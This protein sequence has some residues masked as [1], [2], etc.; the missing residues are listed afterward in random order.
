MRKIKFRVWDIAHGVMDYDAQ[1]VRPDEINPD[2]CFG[3]YLN[4][5][6]DY[7][8]MQFTGLHDKNG[9]EIYEGD[10]V[11]WRYMEEG[12]AVVEYLHD[13]AAYAPFCRLRSEVVSPYEV[14]GNI[15]ENPDLLTA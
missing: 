10:V 3:Q 11:K 5:P 1:D 15:F 12:T 6:E 14:I 7:A 4:Y 13:Y 9:K 2:G 8:V